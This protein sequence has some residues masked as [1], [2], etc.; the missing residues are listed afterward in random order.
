[1]TSKRLHLLL[2][3]AIFLLFL[4]LVGGAYGING[5]LVTQSN[6][7]VSLKATSLA[8]QKQQ[9]D[10]KKAK[11]DIITYTDLQQIT[12][13]IVPEDKNQAEAVREIVNLAGANHINLTSITF[14]ASTLGNA[15]VASTAPASATAAP[16]SATKNSAQSKQNSL[17]QLQVVKDIPG[18][19]LLPIT[20]Q[21]DTD[22]PVPYGKFIAFLNA[23][24]HNRRTA[25]VSNISIAPDPNDHTQLTFTLT[26]NEYIKP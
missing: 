20:V 5:L 21:S 16:S 7:L 10:L 14:P 3:T 18:I 1:M 25:Q 8:L 24:E 4:G 6:K 9:T 13:S 26:L 15:P 2:L 22:Q 17:S 11:K 19:Y 12:R 23:L